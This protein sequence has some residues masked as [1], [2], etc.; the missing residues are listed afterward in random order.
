M[1]RKKNEGLPIYLET[2][3]RHDVIN[4][5]HIKNESIID[6]IKRKGIYLLLN[7]FDDERKWKNVISMVQGYINYYFWIST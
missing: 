2:S 7:S 5:I 3:W 6:T 4:V 1:V